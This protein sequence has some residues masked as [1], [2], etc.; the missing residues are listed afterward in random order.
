MSRRIF[1]TTALDRLV[2]EGQISRRSNAHR[3]IKLVIENG[4]TVLDDD[5][6]TLYDNELIPKIEDVQILRGA[7]ARS[8]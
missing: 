6:R 2:D 4:V 5:Q 8:A 1:L 3:I 7:T